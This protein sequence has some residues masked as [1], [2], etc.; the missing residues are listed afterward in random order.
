MDERNEW[1]RQFDA[2]AEEESTT[3]DDLEISAK[4]PEVEEHE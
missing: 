1:Q 2:S 3:E 4:V